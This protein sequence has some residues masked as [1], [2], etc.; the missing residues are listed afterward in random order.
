LPGHTGRSR[1]RGGPAPAARF[2]RSPRPTTAKEAGFP[3][4]TFDGLVGFFGWAGMPTELRDS[5]A[6]DIREAA[7]DPAIE[8]RLS[9]TGQVPNPGG[10]AEFHAAIEGQRTRIPRLPRTSALCRRSEYISAAT[11]LGSTHPVKAAEMAVD[12]EF[13]CDWRRYAAACCWRSRSQ[14]QGRSSSMRLA[15]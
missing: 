15:G 6:A 4:L 8:E 11:Q 9:L 7:A 3:D 14:F 1:R 5:I 13:C 2:K 10:P 12:G